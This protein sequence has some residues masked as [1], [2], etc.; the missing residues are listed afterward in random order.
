MITLGIIGVVAA[1]T[2]PTLV[3]KY[4]DKVLLSQAK[5]SYSLISN[6]ML[7]TKVD[8]NFDSYG[9]LFNKNRTNDEIIE[10]LSKEF[11]PLKICKEGKGGC[12]T[13]KTKAA[14]ALYSNGKTKYHDFSKYAGMILNDGSVLYVHRYNHQGDCG[15]V[16]EYDKT[17]DKGFVVKDEDGN[18]VKV[19][20]NETRCG[21]IKIDVNGEK[22]PNQ[23][24][25]DTFDVDIRAQKVTLYYYTFLYD[26]TLKYEDYQEGIE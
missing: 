21:S 17:D 3:A 22:G 16:H 8:N 24:G 2:L 9:D 23:L 6:A 4:K 14:K 10:I 13:W 5:R 11:K 18:P 12:W 19:R 26:D 20:S 15:W 7:R 1:M 25:A